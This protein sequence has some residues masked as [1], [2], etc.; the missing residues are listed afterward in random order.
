MLV[1]SSSCSGQMFFKAL[2][3]SETKYDGLLG[4]EHGLRGPLGQEMKTGGVMVDKGEKL[5]RV[6]DLLL[7]RY[8]HCERI[9]S[10]EDVLTR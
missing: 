2:N 5:R 7:R 3:E 8:E 6:K 10:R 4:L 9:Q 1:S